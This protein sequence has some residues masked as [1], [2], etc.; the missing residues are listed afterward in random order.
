METVTK[1]KVLRIGHS[2]DPDDAFMFFALSSGAV[3]LGECRIEHV[4]EDIQSLNQRALK[5]ELEITAISA[6]VYPLIA[7]DYWILSS[8]ASVG[9]NY[10]PMVVAARHF[11]QYELKTKKIA[12]PGFQTTA[13]ILLKIFLGD[14]IPVEMNFADIIP[15]VQSGQVEAGL[16]IHEGQLNYSSFGLQNCMDLGKLW[17]EKYHL[18]IP[19]GLDVVR[20]D[21]GIEAAKKFNRALRESIQFARA[22][23][24]PALDY[25]LKFGRGISKDTA[26]KFLGM[27]V[28]DD[29]ENLGE[30]GARALQILY[31]LGAEKGL[32]PPVQNLVLID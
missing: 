22:Q 8:G 3:S 30:D 27:Y 11:S 26:R 32:F 5:A 2:P 15:A 6:A 31:R 9:R 1:N 16:I 28:N 18:P 10:G 13:Y 21:L 4:I 14:F 25:A 29:T 7:K 20:K 23:E 24:G 12:V 17:F 19:L